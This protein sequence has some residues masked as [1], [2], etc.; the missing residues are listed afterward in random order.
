MKTIWKFP[1]KNQ[2]NQSVELP[3]G[4][5]VLSAHGQYDMICLWALVDPNE[6]VREEIKVQIVGTGHTL[7][8]MSKEW[9]FVDTVLMFGDTLVLH[10]FV[11]DGAEN[12]EHA[13]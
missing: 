8:H 6:K 2:N 5:K 7:E 12:K 9:R 4:A 3:I 10:V 11:R 13:T 1:L